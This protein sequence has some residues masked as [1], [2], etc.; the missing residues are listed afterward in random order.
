MENW[1]KDFWEMMQTFADEA[2]RFF[3][4]MTEM[5]DTLFDFTEDLGEQVQ[6]AISAEVDQYLQD[7]ESLLHEVY[8]ELDDLP[9][10]GLDSAFPYSVEATS[11]KNP[12][13][14]G[15]KHYHGNAYGGNLLV[16]G[17]HPSGYEDIICPD[18]EAEES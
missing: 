15:C 7:T 18:W 8:W 11:E 9:V 12:A 3:A 4:E 10:D 17:M 5:V 16:C 13:C 14:I 2:E 6:N 1:Q